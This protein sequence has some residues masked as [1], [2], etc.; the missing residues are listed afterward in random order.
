MF[1]LFHFF[2][3]L[4]KIAI[5]AAVYSAILWALVLVLTIIFQRQKT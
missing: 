5:Q 3:D 2:S 1:A 4:F